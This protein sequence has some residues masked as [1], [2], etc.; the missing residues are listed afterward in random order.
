MRWVG[1]AVLLAVVA[2]IVGL[3]FYLGPNSLRRCSS[4]P[5]IGT[6]EAADAIVAVSGGDTTARADGAIDL[7]RQGWAPLII[8]SG[9]A[10]DTSG[11]S[12]ALAMKRY[13]MEQ[14]ISEEAIVIEELSRTTAENAANTSQFLEER[15]IDR[16]VLVTSAYHQR[17]AS[18]EFGARL[19]SE[20]TI[21]NR[22]VKTDRQWGSDW[23][24]T[25][26]GWSLAVG[27]LTKIAIFYA[28]KEDVL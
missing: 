12:N 7:Y 20:V 1:A 16:V 15:Q 4:G 22:P 10:A 21:L 24:L 6:C 5:S 3:P 11:P 28:D 25:T 17:R 23:W 27:E 19:G 2:F 9:A 18:L 14:G 26:H 8:F 13:A